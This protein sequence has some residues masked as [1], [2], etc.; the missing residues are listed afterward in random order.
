M[1]RMVYSSILV[2]RSTHYCS[3]S[4]VFVTYTKLV[5]SRSIVG[6]LGNCFS[7]RG[8]IIVRNIIIE[9]VRGPWL[10]YGIN[11]LPP[12]YSGETRWRCWRR[13]SGRAGGDNKS[14]HLDR[15]IRAHLHT[16]ATDPRHPRFEYRTFIQ[17][18][19]TRNF[20]PSPARYT[21]VVSPM[22][23]HGELMVHATVYNTG[24]NIIYAACGRRFRG[25][26]TF[27]R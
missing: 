9:F 24:Y 7:F 22:K 20:N 16:P 5:R 27:L 1:L 14:A 25:P 4:R 26:A 10:H 3:S 19:G 11:K 23:T 21:T 17:T 2:V 13:V 15:I 18:I 12:Y 6:V 8:I